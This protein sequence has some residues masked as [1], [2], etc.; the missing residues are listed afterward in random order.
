[1]FKSETVDK[2]PGVELNHRFRCIRTMCFRYTTWRR[3]H[4]RCRALAV[5]RPDEQARARSAAMTREAF[6]PSLP[7]W[8]DWR[9]PQKP[10]GPVDVCKPI[11]RAAA[12]EKA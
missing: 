6:D 1:M 11:D 3:I 5:A 9:L 10:N 8:K 12:N 4:R 2:S 7:S